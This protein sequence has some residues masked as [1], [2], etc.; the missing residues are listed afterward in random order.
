M[1]CAAVLSGNRNFEARIHPN[2]RANFLASPPLVVAYAIAGTV[3]VDLMTE[4]R[5]QGQGRPG[6]LPRR[7]LADLG[8]GPR[9]AAVR[10]GSEDLQAALQRPHQGPRPLEQGAVVGRPGLQLADSTY[11]AE[12]PFFEDFA[13]TPGADRA[14]S[15][16][17][18][19]LGLFGDSI[20]TDHISPGRLDQGH[21]A[22]RQVPHRERRAA[23][24]TSTATARAA[25]TMK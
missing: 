22:G 16:N 10:D 1:V 17:A 2:I 18:R 3:Q 25:A 8:G 23:R 4:P 13:M 9:A 14:R 12:P 6:R 5:R 21:L 7:H 19:I 24:P 11:I 15:A 20:T